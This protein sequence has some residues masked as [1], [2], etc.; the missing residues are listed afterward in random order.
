MLL[1]ICVLALAGGWYHQRLVLPPMPD[2]LTR[3]VD[4]AAAADEPLSIRVEGVA[5]G[6]TRLLGGAN[7]PAGA[8]GHF[9]YVHPTWAVDVACRTMQ[10]A[11]VDAPE[12]VREQPIGGVLRV[13][14]DADGGRDAL[15][16]DAGTRIRAGDRLFIRGVLRP[17]SA[18]SNPGEPDPRP[19]ARQEGVRGLLAVP[20]E[21][22]I[23]QIEHDGATDRALAPLRRALAGARA[24]ASSILAD[25]WRDADTEIGADSTNNDRARAVGAFDPPNAPELDRTSQTDSRQAQARALQARSLQARALIAS[26]L[27]GVDDADPNLR[28]VQQAFSRLGLLHLIAISGV[29]MVLLAGLG[30]LALRLTGDRGVVEPLTIAALVVVYLLILPAQAPI[31][32]GGVMVLALLLA[33][34]LGRRYD[35]LAVLGW[36][37]VALAIVWPLDVFN[38][39]YQLSFGVVGA[40]LWVQPAFHARL[41]PARIRGVRTTP[42]PVGRAARF[43]RLGMQTRSLVHAV[44]A[45][46]AHALSAAIVAWCVT[47]PVIAYHAGLFTPLGVLFTLLAAPVCALLL[48]GGYIVLLIGAGWRVIAS[49][50]TSGPSG[51]ID[52][53]MGSALEALGRVCVGLV[54]ALDALPGSSLRVPTL[55]PW[56]CAGLAVWAVVMLRWSAARQRA[57]LHT[58]VTEQ[59]AER[60]HAARLLTWVMCS[61]PTRSRVARLGTGAALLAWL[62]VD[63]LGTGLSSSTLRLDAFGGRLVGRNGSCLLVRAS[64]PREG[65]SSSLADSLGLDS[66]SVSTL[67][68]Q[69]AL[70][71][72]PGSSSPGAGL[73]RLPAALRALGAVRTRSAVLLSPSIERFNALPDLAHTVGVRDVYLSPQLEELARTGRTGSATRVARALAET[74]D[75][76][77]AAGVHVHVLRPHEPVQIDDA[78]WIELLSSDS[79]SRDPRWPDTRSS[80]DQTKKPPTFVDRSA[81]LRV[82]SASTN[83]AAAGSGS[84]SII[85]APSLTAAGWE[86]IVDSDVGA[87]EGAS[88]D[89]ASSVAA[90]ISRADAVVLSTGAWDMVRS[91]SW[92]SSARWLTGAATPRVMLIGTPSRALF[93]AA[94]SVGARD[95]HAGTTPLV[96]AHDGHVMIEIDS[97][98]DARATRSTHAAH[99]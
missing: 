91:A 55:S 85:F 63:L 12:R 84:R 69:N 35:R 40:L 3:A 93:E 76:L 57:S 49:M 15:R 28:P 73:D 47:T 94:L 77:N 26:M 16:D 30:V 74:L 24:F 19:R 18:P 62:V 61:R 75:L 6:P 88:T 68:G 67:T 59:R 82:S 5:L 25:A 51:G 38:A 45:R 79:L 64:S 2:E 44:F 14:I 46:T 56:L 34:A 39:G 22:L 52:T 83:H 42:L 8:L 65:A 98:G 80:A 95:Q 1:F 20:S 72:D 17:L 32:R 90:A 48:W 58:A 27:L 92:A 9:A 81:I 31:I 70:L 7:T 37:G 87:S 66:L 11:P 13:R 36:V 86:S 53:A 33:N 10:C 99:N 43:E 50:F 23:K 71:I 60:T 97:D 4:V 41:F 96:P 54:D 89:P 29:N 78:L 21:G